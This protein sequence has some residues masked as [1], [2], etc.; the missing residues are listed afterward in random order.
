[1]NEQKIVGLVKKGIPFDGMSDIR[2]ADVRAE[3]RKNLSRMPIS[4]QRWLSP[5][6]LQGL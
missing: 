1:M 2:I 3:Y 5:S 6:I 4:V